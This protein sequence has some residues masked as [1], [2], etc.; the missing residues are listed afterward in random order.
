[1]AKKTKKPK[2][3]RKSK[4]SLKSLTQ[5]VEG[6]LGTRSKIAEALGVSRSA[7]TQHLQN[8]PE[9]ESIIEK[10]RMSVI[11]KAENELF[12]LLEFDDYDK[13]PSSAARIRQKSAE[14][15]LG[16]LG[17]NKGWT[18]KT[19]V[20]H[21]GD[22]AIVINLVETSVEEIKNSKPTNKPETS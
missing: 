8:Y 18:E 14:Y 13:D 19:E 17:K 22:T 1:M 20:Q 12:D 5:A 9:H 7:L 15:I 3:K 21:S 2:Q 4:I 16:R 11:N 6:T 10:E